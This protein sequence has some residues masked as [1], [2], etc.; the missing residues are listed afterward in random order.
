MDRQTYVTTLRDLLSRDPA[1]VRNANRRLY[2]TVVA[3]DEQ[4]NPRE[5][6]LVLAEVGG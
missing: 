5:A 4:K 6:D 3:P 1:K 2:G